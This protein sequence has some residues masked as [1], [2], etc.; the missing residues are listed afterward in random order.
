VLRGCGDPTKMVVLQGA[1][2]Q[3]T[4]AALTTQGYARKILSWMLAYRLRR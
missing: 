3:G 2:H 1:D 4:V